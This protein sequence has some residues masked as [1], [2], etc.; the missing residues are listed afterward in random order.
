MYFQ[1]VQQMVK[2]LENL[3]KIL[4]KAKQFSENKKI[5]ENNLLNARLVPDQYDLK[6]QLVICSETARLT[7]DYLAG[8]PVT[9]DQ[10]EEK[11]FADIKDRINRA[12]GYINTFSSDDFKNC[13]D[14]KI[15]LPFAPGM[16]LNGEEA[17]LESALPN[18][19]FH[20]VTAYSIL[21]NNGLDIGKQ[22]YIGII[23]FKPVE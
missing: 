5:D 23:N 13:Q 4:D 3:S 21:R 16:Y 1:I 7:A 17:L 14:I 19:Y 10:K 2:M 12:I 18:F 15:T 9:F 11:S 22:D 6:Q 8:K 20:L